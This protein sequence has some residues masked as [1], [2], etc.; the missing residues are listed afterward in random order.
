MTMPVRTGFT[1]I[2]G[3]PPR[4]DPEVASLM[5]SV[6]RMDRENVEEITRSLLRCALGW[7]RT[8]N[9]AYLTSLA[10]DAL[11]AMAD[12]RNPETEEALRVAPRKPAGPEGSVNVDEWLR[13]QG[14]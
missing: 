6:S 12:R 4:N 8:G 11:D 7:R 14:L 1:E 9:P 13:E 5:E 10:D 2:E 3:L